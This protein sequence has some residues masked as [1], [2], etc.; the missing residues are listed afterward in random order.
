MRITR[1]S[2]TIEL[3]QKA[4]FS[5]TP[6]LIVIHDYKKQTNLDFILNLI[7]FLEKTL[8]LKTEF[9]CV[10]LIHYLNKKY[11]IKQ[12]IDPS[13]TT[14][15]IEINTLNMLI[16]R[17]DDST[18]VLI[19]KKNLDSYVI[20]KTI[21][22]MLSIRSFDNEPITKTIKYNIAKKIVKTLYGVL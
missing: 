12:E 13:S 1:N 8:N 11:Y 7:C 3:S 17:L 19:D 16:E 9:D 20:E 6:A 14:K 4:I 10:K 5:N 18:I 2:I 22:N 15:K 21:Y